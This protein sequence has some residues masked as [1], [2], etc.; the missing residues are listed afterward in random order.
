MQDL[1][2]NEEL[3]PAVSP[4][5][6][7]PWL[8]NVLVWLEREAASSTK[9][10]GLLTRLKPNGSSSKMYLAY[11]QVNAEQTWEQLSERWST[12]GMAWPGECLMHST[13]EYPKD[14]G[15][16]SSLRNVLETQPVL[17]KFYLS[18]K[19]CEGILR[20]AER[21]GKTLPEALDRALRNQCSSPSEK[22][23]QGGGKGPLISVDQSLTLATQNSQVLY[24]PVGTLTA[25]GIRCDLNRA[26][27]GHLTVEPI[28]HRM[29]AFGQYADDDDT[30]SSL[31][32]RDYKDATDLVIEPVAFDEMNFATTAMHQTL[33]AGTPQSTGVIEPTLYEPH[34][35]DGRA[36]EGIANTLAARMGTGGNNTPV[37]VEPVAFSQNQREEV[38][39]MELAGT[40][41]AERGTHQQTFI[42]EPQTFV[43]VI[44]SGA[45]D[46]DGNLP[47]EVWR[48]EQTNPTL[49]QFTIDTT[50]AQ[51]VATGTVRRLTPTE[52]E[53][54][55]GFPDG[56]TSQR[57][58]E[59]K[60]LI[61]QADSSRYKQ[62][63]NAVA[64]PCVE[65]IMARLVEQD[66]G[67]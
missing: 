42:A 22:E 64:V 32:A 58:D 11:S 20:R 40:L 8:A 65:W 13:S 48:E 67:R 9:S 47:P 57:I 39:I 27:S 50:G 37:L 53:R 63:G 3:L 29:T 23:S 25:A 49:N 54:L 26:V 41:A 38:R 2:L 5:K 6:T 16:S 24:E 12:S 60:G 51:S 61:E 66:N 46:A 19:A 44:R 55:Q 30:S 7:Y 62:M 56:W 15:V 59:K 14:G 31:K 4:A 17:Q 28:V 34:H 10:P 18:A 1:S 36:T 21:R 35:G 45:R 43:K 33:R 52:C